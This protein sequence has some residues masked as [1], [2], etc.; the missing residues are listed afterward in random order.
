MPGSLMWPSRKTGKN[1]LHHKVAKPSMADAHEELLGVDIKLQV[2]IS[3][4]LQWIFFCGRRRCLSTGHH[5]WR[6]PADQRGIEPPPVVYQL[7][8]RDAFSK[9]L[10]WDFRPAAGRRSSKQRVNTGSGDPMAQLVGRWSCQRWQTAGGG[11]NPCWSTRESQVRPAERQR[12][13]T[14]KNRVQRRKIWPM[15]IWKMIV[16]QCN[17]RANIWLNAIYVQTS[18]NLEEAALPIVA[19]AKATS[20]PADITRKEN[21]NSGARAWSKAWDWMIMFTGDPLGRPFWAKSVLRRFSGPRIGSVGASCFVMILFLV[22]AS[23][24]HIGCCLNPLEVSF[25]LFRCVW[26]LD[27]LP[28]KEGPSAFCSP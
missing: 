2:R 13:P 12:A 17:I 15:C 23:G 18:D 9:A 6:L 25:L 8:H 22:G 28:L 24:V 16:T 7:L 3:K 5:T 11:S 4:A 14:T 19:V 20:S 10:Q 27:C 26:W 21:E 1:A